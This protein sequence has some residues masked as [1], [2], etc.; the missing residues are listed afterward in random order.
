[1]MMILPHNILRITVPLY[2]C[3]PV[4]GQQQGL[5]YMGYIIIKQ[6][7]SKTVLFFLILT[8]TLDSKK[9]LYN[10]WY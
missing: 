8:L 2:H 4:V 6:P 7:A 9:C 10:N 1:M 5:D 3:G